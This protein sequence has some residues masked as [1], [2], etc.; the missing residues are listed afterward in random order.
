MYKFSII[1]PV[2]CNPKEVAKFLDSLHKLG[3]RGDFEVILVDDSLNNSVKT[4][5]QKFKHL[6]IKLIELK[7]RFFIGEKRNIGTREAK[8]EI[9]FFIDSDIILEKD[10][11]NILLQSM[12]ENPQ[13]AMFGG[14]IMQAGKKLHPTKND[15]LI[16]HGTIEYCEVIYSAY[17]CLYKSI[18]F[19]LG[20]YDEIFENRG[21][22]TDLSIK[23]W[24][25]GFPLA[26]NLKSIV[27]HPLFKSQRKSPD[28]IA[29][30]Y[31]SLFL[32]AYKY[33]INP[34]ENPHLIEMYQERKEAYG[35]TCEFYSIYAT[36]KYLDWFVR[37]YQ[38]IRKSKNNIPYDFDFKPF[39]IFSNKELLN[40]CLDKALERINPYYKKV[41]R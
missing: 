32:V 17:L 3:I 7:K 38:A 5:I 37:N 35:E 1:S 28:R 6:P 41:F 30:M 15:R 34:N 20:G 40:K 16:R 36:A 27:H 21:E 33:G 9:I 11:L 10:S 4:V 19:K 24:R 14:T 31:R 26:R 23:F 13:V 25:A 12:K 18:F 39:D 8:N 29:E 22:G 2:Y